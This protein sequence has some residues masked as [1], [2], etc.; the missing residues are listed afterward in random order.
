MLNPLNSFTITGTL[1]NR[2]DRENNGKPFCVITIATLGKSKWNGKTHTG[3]DLT[4]LEFSCFGLS[5]DKAGMVDLGRTVQVVGHMEGREY[6]GKRYMDTR[7]DEFTVV[8]EINATVIDG[9][10]TPRPT[11]KSAAK[12]KASDGLDFG[13]AIPADNNDEIPF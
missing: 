2:E 10:Q 13:G 11:A 5:Y 9:N 3:F 12:A 7:L 4:E 6:N 8:P 1:T